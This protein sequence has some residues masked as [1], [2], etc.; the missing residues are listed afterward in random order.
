MARTKWKLDRELDQPEDEFFGLLDDQELSE[1]P[2]SSGSLFSKLMS[3]L[4]TREEEEDVEDELEELVV[5][6]PSTPRPQEGD[7]EQHIIRL[8]A[9]REWEEFLEAEQSATLFDKIQETSRKRFRVSAWALWLA[10][11]LW[12][13]IGLKSG[14]AYLNQL[15][16]PVVS[17]WMLER[18]T[19][20][21]A[22]IATVGFAVLFPVAG[23]LLSASSLSFLLGGIYEKRFLRGLFGVCG[24]IAVWLSLSLV[25][26]GFYLAGLITAALGW[27]IIRALEWVMLRLGVY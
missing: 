10:A 19:E 23:F 15:T 27:L 17:Q 22:R 24:L 16:D 25:G 14:S 1:A 2:A 5:D 12:V 20:R 21:T 18:F 3:A 7:L 11:G 26:Q 13:L 8:P 6:R 4:V 9:G